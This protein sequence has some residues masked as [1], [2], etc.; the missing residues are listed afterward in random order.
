MPL[1]KII[2]PINR[3]ERHSTNYNVQSTELL[4]YSSTPTTR[5]LSVITEIAVITWNS[6]LLS[7]MYLIRR[8]AYPVQPLGVLCNLD[9][10]E[11]RFY[12]VKEKPVF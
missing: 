11:C 2:S 8:M 1:V 10:V 12:L 9:F 5:I 7:G 3:I 4:G 6:M